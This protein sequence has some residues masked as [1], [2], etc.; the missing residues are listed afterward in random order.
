MITFL[1]AATVG[2]QTL[3]VPHV[4]PDGTTRSVPVAVWYPT[5]KAPTTT[6]RY[7]YVSG[8]VVKNGRVLAGAWPLVVVS[9]GLYECGTAAALLAQFIAAAGYIVAAPDHE[10]AANCLIGGGT[11]PYTW[12]GSAPPEEAAP[13]RPGEFSSVVGALLSRFNVSEVIAAGHSLGGWTITAAQDD[14]VSATI[15]WSI[16][17][18]FAPESSY[19]LARSPTL[20]LYGAQ[21]WFVGSSHETAAFTAVPSQVYQATVADAGHY[22]FTDKQHCRWYWTVE[23]CYRNSATQQLILDY[24]LALLDAVTQN[25]ATAWATLRGLSLVKDG[26]Y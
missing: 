16:G 5:P 20:L 15:L 21:E 11:A 10:D 17:P 7:A 18:R 9:H 8:S 25:D 23:S 12:L 3:Q 13:N 1:L 19:A 2:F 14:R 26:T 4:R 24:S 22:A 6:Q